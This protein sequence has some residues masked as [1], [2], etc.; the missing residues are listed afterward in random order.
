[1]YRNRDT[2][3][4]L[5]R[6][7]LS[8]LDAARF[9]AGLLFV[10]DAC[11]GGSLAV[12]EEL[13][14]RDPRVSVLDLE[15]NVGQHWAVLTGLRFVRSPYTVLMDADLQDPPEAVP[16]LL[17]ALRAGQAACVFAG[18]RGRYQAAHRHLTSRLFKTA[19]RAATGLPADAGIFL[20]MNEELRSRLIALN[21]PQPFVV[22]MIG[23]TRL[24]VLSIPVERARRPSGASAYSSWKRLRTGF[25]AIRLALEY[26]WKGAAWERAPS[27]NP[28]RIRRIIGPATAI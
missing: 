3:A 15:R 21:A 5:S 16:V 13:A 8:S 22:A 11:P 14:R 27:H 1:V 28:A 19:L 10:N 26:R 17:H 12:L 4:E 2:L 23:C 25:A 18:R 6:R 9:P 24:P 20:A 7:V